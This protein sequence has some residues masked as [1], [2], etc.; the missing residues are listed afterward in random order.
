MISVAF[1]EYFFLLGSCRTWSEE[2]SL[3]RLS[4]YPVYRSVHILV[5]YL[6]FY[7]IVIIIIVVVIII[8][9]TIFMV[10][11]IIIFFIA[12]YSPWGPQRP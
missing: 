3:A 5:I 10:I 12:F 11:I 4:H 9:V 6:L 2:T 8:I 1:L 7:Y